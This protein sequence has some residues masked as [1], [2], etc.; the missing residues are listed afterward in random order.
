MPFTLDNVAETVHSLFAEDT[1]VVLQLAPSEEVLERQTLDT[2][3]FS[4]VHFTKMSPCF[5]TEALHV[6]QGQRCV[7]RPAGDSAADPSAPVPGRLCAQLPTA[8]LPQQKCRGRSCTVIAVKYNL[9]K[10]FP[11]WPLMFQRIAFFFS[12]RFAFLVWGSSP[13]W[14]HSPGQWTRAV[15]SILPRVNARS[16]CS[17]S[18]SQLQ[19]HKH[20]AKDHSPDVYSLELSGLEELSRLYGQDSPQYQDAKAILASVLQKVRKGA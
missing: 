18:L 6:G 13:A 2:A 19:R 5:H 12:G 20:L 16:H 8:Q 1:P 17:S 10:T 11:F 15:Q 4:S 9:T 14:Y 3:P 7:W